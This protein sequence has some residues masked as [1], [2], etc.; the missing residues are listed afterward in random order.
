VVAITVYR[1]ARFRGT[2]APQ[3]M[4]QPGIFAGC[5]FVG[6][7]SAWDGR[8]PI[9]WNVELEEDLE[10]DDEK[11]V[12]AESASFNPVRERVDVAALARWLRSDWYHGMVVLVGGLEPA[13]QEEVFHFCRALAAPVLVEATSGLREARGRRA[14]PEGDRWLDQRTPGRGRRW[15]EVPSGR[16]WRNLEA[17]PDVSV[18][19]VCR[20]G[21]PGLARE[22]QVVKGGLERVLPA[23][24]E[25]AEVGDVLDLLS[26]RSRRAM[27]LDELLE[28]YPD[29]EPGLV[30]LLSQYASL[31]SGIFLGN[32]M[33]I[34]EWNLF[35]Q[36]RQPCMRVRANRGVNGIDGQLSTWLGWSA[37]SENA[38]AVVGDLTALYDLAAGGFLSQVEGR[39]RKLVVINN[40][41]G[42]IFSRLPRLAT[43]SERAAA[44]MLNH[45][46]ADLAGLA[47]LWGLQH[48]R[49][50]TA[51]DFDLLPDEHAEP[52]LVEILPDPGQTESFWQAWD[53]LGAEP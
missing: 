15:G 21:L 23:L 8:G 32:S 13:E 38:W 25:V 4:Q 33:P 14:G 46:A 49:I 44:W 30:R 39:G 19:S 28:S 12:P 5:A 52:L 11:V 34:R 16:Y 53:R 2:G 29:S 45:H 27:R 36:W 7:W 43:M 18:W 51:D 37:A 31:G 6:E 50:R 10:F 1:P 22:S 24:G 48:V 20:N 40:R 41:G 17:M 26:L 9:H 47:T 35:A 42:G 3:T